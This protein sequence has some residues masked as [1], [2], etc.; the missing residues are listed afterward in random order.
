MWLRLKGA[1]SVKESRWEK[2]DVKKKQ[3]ATCLNVTSSL[4]RVKGLVFEYARVFSLEKVLGTRTLK[5]ILRPIFASKCSRLKFGSLGS[6]SSPQQRQEKVSTKRTTR[7]NTLAKTQGSCE[8]RSLK[9][10]NKKTTRTLGFCGDSQLKNL[11]DTLV[12]PREMVDTDRKDDAGF[13]RENVL[14]G[15]P[16]KDVFDI[17]KGNEKSG[18]SLGPAKIGKIIE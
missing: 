14:I 9:S 18:L 12:R 13:E 6:E 5:I 17:P 1:T 3:R 15:M 7:F 4:Q 16:L 10:L 11:C 8:P 2:L